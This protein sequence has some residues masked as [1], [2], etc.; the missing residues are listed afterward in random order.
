MSRE[1]G[2]GYSCGRGRQAAGWLAGWLAVLPTTDHIN[3]DDD[4]QP[5]VRSASLPPLP[6]LMLLLLMLLLPLLPSL[7]VCQ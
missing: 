5:D 3:T 7:Y 1:A 2:C 4:K 6:T